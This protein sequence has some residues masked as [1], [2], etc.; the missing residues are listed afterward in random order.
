M[1]LP[2]KKKNQKSNYYIILQENIKIQK[3]VITLQN[4]QTL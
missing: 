3:L 1:Y 2:G 4:I